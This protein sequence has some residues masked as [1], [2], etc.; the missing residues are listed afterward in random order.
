[1]KKLLGIT[2][3]LPMLSYAATVKFVEELIPLQVNEQ[4]VEHSFFSSV[5]EI[6]LPAGVH[7]I[8]LKYK[9]IYE[10]DYDEHETVESKP[11]WLIVDIDDANRDYKLSIQRADDI[12]AAKKYS[13]QP[14]ADFEKLGS[15]EKPKRLN[16]VNTKVVLATNVSPV[17]AA[18]AATS[19]TQPEVVTPVI[20][21]INAVAPAAPASQQPSA[22]NM[23]EFWWS[24]ASEAEKNAFLSNK[25]GS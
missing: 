24:Q 19:N 5:S 4:K 22:L 3:L 9:D 14:Y 12:S 11:F 13:K 23:L 17:P 18:V 16:A 7:K 15:T 25:K 1:M 20:S 6:N 21:E 10:V 2:L 8:K